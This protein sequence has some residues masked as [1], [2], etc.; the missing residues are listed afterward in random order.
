[1]PV[2]IACP[3]PEC[4]TEYKVQQESLGGRATCKKCGTS[5]TLQLSTGD[6]LAPKPAA[7]DPSPK[8]GDAAAAIPAQPV[9]GSPKPPSEKAKPPRAP[10]AAAVPLPKIGRYVVKRR[11]GA[12]AM[13]EVWLARDPDLERDVAI[14]TLRREY[15]QDPDYLRRFLRE[16]RSAAQLHH[17]NT[18][19]IYQVGAEKDMAFI[20]MEMVEGS[21]LDKVL[22]DRGPLPWREATQIIRDAARGLAVAHEIGVVH[23][24]LKPA[25]LMYTSK[26]VTKVVDFGLARAGATD[27]QI[28]QKGAMLGTPAFMAPELWAGE[29]AEARSDLYALAISYYCLL[30]NKLPYEAEMLV[31]VGYQHRYEP[32]PDPRAHVAGLPDAVCRILARGARKEPGERY[33]SAAELAAELDA[34]L[35][36]P[37]ESLT[38]DASWHEFN[39]PKAGGSTPGAAVPAGSIARATPLA[40]AASP[41]AQRNRKLTWSGSSRNRLWIGGALGLLLGSLAVGAVM[42][43]GGMASSVPATGPTNPPMGELKQPRPR[44][45]TMPGP[46]AISGSPAE[47]ATSQPPIPSKPGTGPAPGGGPKPVPGGLAGELAAAPVTPGP[48]GRLISEREAL[49]R[50][51]RQSQ[52]WV[53]LT[54]RST[55]YPGDR[56]LSLP[57]YRSNLTLTTAGISLQLLGGTL[58]ELLPPDSRGVP[59]LRLL[60][61][62]AV[63]L[64]F[65]KPGAQIKLWSGIRQGFVTFADPD[66]TLAVEVVRMR[67]DGSNPEKEPATAVVNLYSTAGSTAWSDEM[68]LQPQ[69]LQAPSRMSFSATVESP[70]VEPATPGEFPTWIIKTDARPIIEQR[71]SVAVEEMLEVEDRRVI[72]GLK[73]M[74]GHHH[75]EVGSLAVQCLAEIDEFESV[76]TALSNPGQRGAWNALVDSLRTAI[77][78]SPASAA[79][80]RQAFERHRGPEGGELYRMLWGYSPE[81]LQTG[82]AA[83]LVKYLDHKDLDFRVLA[84]WNLTRIAGSNGHFYRPTDTVAKRLPALRAWKQKLD[85]G[86]LYGKPLEK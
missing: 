35:A 28:T 59:G 82:A 50:F 67:T 26:G 9:Q 48:V 68:P 63:L 53:R 32:F 72:L 34:L 33:P 14:K 2:K 40:A 43:S 70:S 49:L 7:G 46:P 38:L 30:T 37:A 8:P 60:D 10:G 39:D 75:S 73:E 62:R 61:G 76:V 78:R 31:Q 66:S 15:A 45:A 51:D 1:M 16:A 80:V 12:G 24:D 5:F 57:T 4:R 25:N 41:R 65:G 74:I 52:A 23:R 64:A 21:S 58:V 54:T 29:S 44:P 47:L 20:A 85:S 79:K 71:A 77:A 55:V 22:K 27:S 84:F 13:G 19:S 3:N 18:V 69:R 36:S 86:A 81:Q 56:R 17:Q 11:L 83:Q 42:L 6:T